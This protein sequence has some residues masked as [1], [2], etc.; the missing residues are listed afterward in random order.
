MTKVF[1]SHCSE[2]GGVIAALAEIW[3][4]CGE[5]VELFYSSDP[6]TGIPAGDSLLRRIS[7]EIEQCGVFVPVLTENYARS[8]YCVYEL[9][10][11]V[12]LRSCRIVPICS[13]AAQFDALRSI[14]AASDLRYIDAESPDAAAVMLE[15]F[16]W[17]KRAK[18]AALL[19]RTAS[20]LAALA[21]SPPSRRPF[22]GMTREAY[23]RLPGY[24]ASHG[25]DA[26]RDV[27]LPPETIKAHLR[28][29][30]RITLF[31]TTGA[32]LLKVISADAVTDALLRGADIRVILPNPYSDFCADV[33]AI[34]EDGDPLSQEANLK[35]LN[36]EYEAVVGFLQEAVKA[37]SARA[38]GRPVGQAACYCAYTLLRQ[39]VFLAEYGDGRSWGWSSLTMPPLRTANRS[40]LLELHGTGVSGETAE[41]LCVHCDAAARLAEKRGHWFPVRGDGAVRPFF[42]EK[43]TARLYWEERYREASET[44]EKRRGLSETALIEVAAQHPLRGDGTPGIEFAAR[45]DAAA[46]L[47]EKLLRRGWEADIYIPGSRH[48]DGVREDICTLSEAGRRYLLKK[49]L[50]EGCLFGDESNRA[51]KGDDGVYNSADECFVASRLFLGGDYA[52]L[53]CV[54]SPNQ[55]ARKT[56]F[57][58]EF[59][60]LP[61]CCSVPAERM[62]HSMIHELLDSVDGVLYGDHSWQD[63]ASEAFRETRA[64]RIPKTKLPGEP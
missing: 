28:G 62:Y 5:E 7:G 52:A 17:M 60:V 19:D 15:S 10:A 42:L 24:C 40:L 35:R 16:P 13:S 25:I 56:L 44:M 29:A 38:D 22:I 2:D 51:F 55:V 12:C 8:L 58:L 32:G 45:L 59:G 37:A 63:P 41:L 31:T 27:P 46:E 20:F 53:Y 3:R 18:S 30:K 21:G 6:E 57:Y 33:A 49:G 14:L 48:R 50:P 23:D 4:E 39:T 26:V 34:E 11:A 61:L 36:S 9:S 1:I 64:Q 47:R 43:T 54:C